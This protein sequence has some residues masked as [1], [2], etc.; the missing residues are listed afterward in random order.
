[1]DKETAETILNIMKAFEVVEATLRVF[2]EEGEKDQKRIAELERR[3]TEL[4]AKTT[5]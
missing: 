3:V 4:E 5:K 2:A 1:M